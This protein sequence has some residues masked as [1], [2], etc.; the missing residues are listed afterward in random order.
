MS[1]KKKLVFHITNYVSISGSAI[2]PLDGQERAENCMW[3]VFV[4]DFFT[5]T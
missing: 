5:K 1:V 4:T 2:C 3:I